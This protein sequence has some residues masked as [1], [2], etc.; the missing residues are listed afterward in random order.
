VFVTEA[1]A[2]RQVE[3]ARDGRDPLSTGLYT[4]PRERD[5]TYVSMLLNR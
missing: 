1:V 4:L 5:T 2:L 3:R